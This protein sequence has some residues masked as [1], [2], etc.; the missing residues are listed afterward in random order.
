MERLK[1]QNPAFLQKVAIAVSLCVLNAG[2]QQAQK[3]SDNQ[4]QVLA[5]TGL[6]A[7]LARNVL[8]SEF[9]VAGLM[10]PGTDPHLYKST[11]GDIRAMRSADALVYTGLRLEGKLGEVFGGQNKQKTVVELSAGLDSLALINSQ[12]FAD[13]FDPH[14]WMDP[15][16]WAQSAKELA[17]V[18]SE[19]YPA[20]SE[21]IA[22]KLK[23]YLGRLDSLD[24]AVALQIAVLPANRRVIVTTH[25]ALNYY[26]AHYDLEV[27]S[28]QG[29]STAAD[30]GVRDIT[31]L[32]NFI[33]ERKIPAVFVENIVS[34]RS[35]D[36]V[37]QGCESQGYPVKLG[38]SFY[39]DAL[40]PA[41]SEA[42][43]YIEMIALN[44]AVLVKALETQSTV[45]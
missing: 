21:Q 9:H 35:L 43:N 42:E 45:Q 8:P 23:H 40:G 33:I 24:R 5:T 34:S 16:L 38:G 11:E 28:L 32:V 13:G 25:D 7:D 22:L 15:V 31:E 30:F 26:A 36:A 41:G 6:A 1:S 2:C 20:H 29:F 18:F 10:G 14:F 4:I 39:T 3:S 27:R 19:D 37:I 17:R 44:T 12:G